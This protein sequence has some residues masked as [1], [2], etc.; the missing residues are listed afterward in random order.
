[1]V[2]LPIT[3]RGDALEQEADRTADQALRTPGA[4]PEM[5]VA[6]A[7]AHIHT[8]DRAAWSADKLNARAYTIG[9]DI[10]F[11]AGQ[12]CFISSAILSGF[13]YSRSVCFL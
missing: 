9:D 3:Q 5:G 10:V 4:I 1:M 8:S 2:A 7:R 13:V 6:L 11:G 12:F